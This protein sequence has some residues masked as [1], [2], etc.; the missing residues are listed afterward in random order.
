MEMDVAFSKF[1]HDSI[2]MG[3][4]E[5]LISTSKIEQLRRLVMA[6]LGPVL[7]IFLLSKAF[8]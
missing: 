1:V 2:H 4:S 3:T 7:L 5:L 8:C 6:L